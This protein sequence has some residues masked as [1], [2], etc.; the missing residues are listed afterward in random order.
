MSNNNNS[1][2]FASAL[3][4][5]IKSVFKIIIIAISWGIRICGMVL[6]KLGEGLDKVVIKKSSI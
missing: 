6:T 3:K 5:L 4:Q 1:A 2:I